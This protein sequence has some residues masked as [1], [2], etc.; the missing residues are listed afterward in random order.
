MT[1]KERRGNELK[2]E[3]YDEKPFT[4]HLLVVSVRKINDYIGEELPSTLHQ[5]FT[6]LHLLGGL[7]DIWSDELFSQVTSGEECLCTLH[8]CKV[9]TINK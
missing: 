5:P 2:R 4:L 8:L 1:K 3:Y 7:Y 6:T 9:H